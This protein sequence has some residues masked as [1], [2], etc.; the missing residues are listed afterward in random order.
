MSYFQKYQR[1][2]VSATNPFDPPAE[3]EASAEFRSIIPS[4]KKIAT[5][6]N[7]I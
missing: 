7:P 1:T 5:H 6:D 2:A 4:I 3:S